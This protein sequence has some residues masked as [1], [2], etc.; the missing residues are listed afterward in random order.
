MNEQVVVP[1]IDASVEGSALEVLDWVDSLAGHRL[2][3]E[4]VPLER[5]GEWEEDPVT[6]TLRHRSGRFFSVVGTEVRSRAGGPAWCQPVLDQSDVGVLGLLAWDDDSTL[7]VL[8]QGK[9]EPGNVNGIQISPTVQ[10]TSSNYERVHGG[11]PVAHLEHFRDVGAH[12][13]TDGGQSE[14][15]GWFHCKSNRNVVVRIPHLC[16]PPPTL[17]WMSLPDLHRMLEL[18]DMV[19]MDMRTVLACLPMS[20]THLLDRWGPADHLP[21]DLVGGLARSYR[22]ARS[23]DGGLV[24]IEGALA[25]ARSRCD[26]LVR[27]TGLHALPG[28]ERVDGV[29]RHVGR[30]HFEVIGVEV[31]GE[32]REVARWSQPMVA[33][34]DIGLAALLIARIDGV[35]HALVSLRVEFG[36]RHRVEIGPTVVERGHRVGPGEPGHLATVLSHCPDGIRFDVVHSEEGGRLFHTRTRY[37]VVEGRHVEPG[38][39]YRWVTLGQMEAL[40]ARGHA[41]TI[42]ARSLL[43]CVQTLLTREVPPDVRGI[44]RPRD[45]A[46]PGSNSEHGRQPCYPRDAH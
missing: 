10:A 40:V 29:L 27:R 39:D 9:A 33:A 24:E 2:H 31:E 42:E 23:V 46:P 43:L 34:V 15:G 3:V 45:G 26:L 35:V 21:D 44:P 7:H 6:G 20:A 41:V 5:L 16:E 22:S 1:K 14:H 11:R 37:L 30:R 36:L 28:W 25:Q 8:V 12:R 18:D 38:T 13:L 19:N 4:R 17:R 32:G